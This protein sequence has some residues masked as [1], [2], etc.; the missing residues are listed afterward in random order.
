MTTTEAPTIDADVAAAELERLAGHPDVLNGPPAPATT[1]LARYRTAALATDAPLD[2]ALV[3]LRALATAD[4]ET[5]GGERD[6]YG[7]HYCR[8]FGRLQGSVLALVEHLCRE[9]D[10][11]VRAAPPEAL[12]ELVR[13]VMRECLAPSCGEQR[14][15]WESNVCDDVQCVREVH[16]AFGDAS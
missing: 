2:A 3:Y 14:A 7:M 8:A 16:G 15:P 6:D 9:I 13:D 11:E 4:V 12:A 5:L 1:P 10:D